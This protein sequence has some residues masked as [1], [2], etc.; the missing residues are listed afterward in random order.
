M[1][2]VRCR[3]LK[4]KNKCFFTLNCAITTIPVSRFI[5][6]FSEKKQNASK[7]K[8]ARGEEKKERL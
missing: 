2:F 4:C 7:K 5:W 6:Y 3:T 8:Q 1:Y